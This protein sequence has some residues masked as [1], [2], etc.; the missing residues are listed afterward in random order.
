MSSVDDAHLGAVVREKR[1][2]PGGWTYGT[3]SR[4]RD[5]LQSVQEEL[6]FE[7]GNVYGVTLTYGR[8]DGCPSVETIRADR[9]ALIEFLRR[10]GFVAWHWLVEFQRDGTPHYHLIVK[11]PTSPWVGRMLV[12]YWVARTARHGTSVRGQNVKRM[13]GW[14]GYAQYLA[15]H[16]SRQN[17]H[18]QRRKLPASWGGYSGRMWGF[19]GQ[20][21]FQPEIVIEMGGDNWHKARRAI[22]RRLMRIHRNR[23]PVRKSYPSKAHYLFAHMEWAR[24]MRYLRR[25]FKGMPQ[26]LRDAFEHCKNR[27]SKRGDMTEDE[28]RRHWCRSWSTTAPLGVWMLE[29]MVREVANIKG[30][31]SVGTAQY[32]S[33]DDDEPYFHMSKL[34]PTDDDIEELWDYMRTH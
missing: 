21:D 24:S 23:K 6:L 16:A 31:Q 12:D 18:Y 25:M 5:K 29:A 32:R 28:M 2:R 17:W 1:E 33:I 27:P 9:E 3:F 20:W 10:Q 14:E 22:R 30:M 34:D 4:L 19:G 15:K 13:W 7:G 8:H 11:H 26:R